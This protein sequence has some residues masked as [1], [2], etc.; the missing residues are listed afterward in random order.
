MND[1][2]HGVKLI[3]ASAIVTLSVGVIAPAASFAVDWPMFLKD[4][5]HTSVA[6]QSP[7]PPLKFKWKFATGAPIFSSPIAY[8]NVVYAGSY[9]KSMYA[10]DAN[11]GKLLWKYDTGGEIL[12]TPAAADN[13]VFFGSKDN[14]IYALDASTGKLLWKYDTGGPVLTSPAVV[15]NK[16]YIA[17]MDLYIYCLDAA[18]GKREWRMKLI[19]YEAYGGIFSSP[20]VYKGSVFIAGKNGSVYS[21]SMNSGGKNWTFKTNSSIYATPAIIDDVLYITSY[22]RTFYAM[23][24]KTGKVKW[25]KNLENDLVYASPV[26][27]HRSITIAFKN[28]AIKTY[29]RISGIET[30]SFKLPNGISST[31]VSTDNGKILLVGCEDGIFYAMDAKDGNIFWKFTTGAGIHG[32]PAVVNNA[33]YITSEDGS[34]YALTQ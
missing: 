8:N 16:V 23:D 26:V 2:H 17:S 4:P 7:L 6:E 3:L 29:D 9:D 11:S 12:S 32:S 22:D 34:V 30:A 14:S 25:R 5:A 20:A 15:A 27:T 28:G 21:I 31:P 10:L 13:R 18:T 33:V 24:V 19:D 1:R